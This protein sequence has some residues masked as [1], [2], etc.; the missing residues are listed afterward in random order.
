M[1]FSST[2]WISASSSSSLSLMVLIVGCNPLSMLMSKLTVL[3]ALSLVVVKSPSGPASS[4]VTSIVGKPLETVLKLNLPTSFGESYV[5][6]ML[7][8]SC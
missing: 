7:S 4:A 3:T 5:T 8:I 6:I 1:P 2:T